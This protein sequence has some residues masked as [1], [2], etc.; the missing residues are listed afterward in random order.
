VRGLVRH[1]LV[2]GT[3]IALHI[4]DELPGDRLAALADEFF[5]WMHEVDHR[6]STYKD[7][8][9]LC[10]LD[11]GEITLAE[12]S[13][14]M[15]EVLDTCAMLK[16]DTLGYFDVYATG[17]LDPSGYVKGWSAEVASRRLAR[18]GSHNH[19][20]NAGGDIRTRGCPEP[21][22]RWLV[23]L[24]HPWDPDG[25]FLMLAGNDLGVATSGTYERG[26]HVIDPLTGKPAELMRSV[27]VAGPNLALADAYA[28]AG[29]A[30]GMPGLQWL[31]ELPGYHVAV[32][33]EDG[34]GFTSPDL[35]QVAPT[36]VVA[37]QVP[38]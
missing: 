38:D 15:R 1:E 25:I 11:R 23:P 14:D 20:I 24:R 31:S 3:M 13:A 26:F 27:T 30:M 7:D 21:G 32:I 8:S 18:A 12:C 28:T 6:F 5:D 34:Q 35:P 9:E 17:R 19:F 33:T 37:A 2:M 29:V 36:S 16:Q 22:E 10:R 4:T